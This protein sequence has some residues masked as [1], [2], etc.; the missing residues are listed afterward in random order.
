MD[1]HRRASYIS[2]P[3]WHIT[4][5]LFSV[6]ATSLHRSFNT[7]SLRTLPTILHG[8]QGLYLTPPHALHTWFTEPLYST[9]L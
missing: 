4:H 8:Q 3:H 1:A 7:A 2:L 6:T 5:L 9:H